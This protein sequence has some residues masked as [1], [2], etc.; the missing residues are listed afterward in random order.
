MNTQEP[1]CNRSTIIETNSLLSFEFEEIEEAMVAL[2]SQEA[3]IQ[4]L[5]KAL[6][7]KQDAID[8]LTSTLLD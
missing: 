3:R 5:E 6:E 2:D 1:T 4:Q 8:D 7:R